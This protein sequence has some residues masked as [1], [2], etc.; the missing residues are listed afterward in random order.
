M[1]CE[2]LVA[3]KIVRLQLDRLV[4]QAVAPSVGDARAQLDRLVRPGFVTAAGAG[5]LS[6][7][8]RYVRGIG[9][10]LDKLPESPGRDQQLMRE[11]IAVERRYAKFVSGLAPS[12]RTREVVEVGWTL[13]ELRVSL[14]AQTLG[15]PVPVSVKRI[16][17]ALTGLESAR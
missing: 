17:K 4:T 9:R 6:D 2:V 13:E 7:L 5:R 1:A 15:T 14:F 3:T 11:A 12:Q 8:L 16:E 10:R